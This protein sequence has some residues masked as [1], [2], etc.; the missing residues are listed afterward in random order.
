MQVAMVA[1]GFSATEADQLR[2]SMATF[3]FTGG[4]HHFKD[5]LIKG[6]IDNGYTP[7]FA[8]RTFR[9]LEGFGSY[10]FP[11]S[12][13]A[14]FALI[15]YA[16]SWMKC[17]HPDVFCCA[18]LNAQPMGFYDPSQ[19]VLDARQH[20]VEVRPIDI[21]ASDLDCTLEPRDDERRV[22]RLGLK[23][24]RGLAEKDALLLVERRGERPFASILDVARRTDLPVAALVFLARADAFRSLGLSRREAQWAI[25]ALKD[26]TLPLLA[27][28]DRREERH[29]PEVS[30]AH[31]SLR[32]MTQ[33]REVVEDYRSHG[34]TLRSHPLAF[35]RRELAA[36]GIIPCAALQETRDGARVSVAGLVL[37]RQ[38][39]GSAKGV[40]FITLEDESGVANLIVWPKTFEGYRRVVLES[41]MMVCTGRVQKASG[42]IHVIAQRMTDQSAILARIGGLDETFTVQT[43]RGDEAKHAGGTDP[44]GVPKL[45]D[46]R[47]IFI[48]LRRTPHNKIHAEPETMPSTFPKS[49]DFK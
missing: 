16:S 35:L 39:P 10:G 26:G 38:R 12:H 44:R 25:K 48:P 37:V 11:E 5:K 28:A 8:E 1:A 45:R 6:M 36:S 33:G 41:Q 20:D 30:E 32:P 27:E 42:V 31:V 46:T 15:A 22:V 2:R 40:M 21:N 43:G 7:E 9:Q 17:H 49:R 24:T 47:D 4:V 29:L 19:L 18:I 14:S 3:K 13:A 23:M 34:L